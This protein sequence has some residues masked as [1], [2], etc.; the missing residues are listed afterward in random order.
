MVDR[1]QACSN[2]IFLVAA[3]DWDHNLPQTTTNPTAIT[4]IYTIDVTLKFA[5]TL[6][7]ENV[8][9]GQPD[10]NEH[11]AATHPYY[12][13]FWLFLQNLQ[14]SQTHLD[15]INIIACHH[16]HT[17]QLLC[18]HSK[19]KL[20]L[21]NNLLWGQLCLWLNSRAILGHQQ[22]LQLVTLIN[23]H[24]ISSFTK[25]TNPP[26]LKL[27]HTKTEVGFAVHCRHCRWQC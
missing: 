11:W 6:L 26:Q 3:T 23:D 21:A 22:T 13:Q 14:L 7:Q 24:N 16:H 20:W 27:V 5:P 9:C 12:L 2:N 19:R 4:A 8:S 17:P 18:T 10:Q 1:P 15:Q 25:I